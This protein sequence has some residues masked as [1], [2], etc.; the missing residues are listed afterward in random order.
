[1]QISHPSPQPGSAAPIG[2][3]R[4]WDAA[5]PVLL[6]EASLGDAAFQAAV[7]AARDKSCSD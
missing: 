5:F 2:H 4:C 1:M 6:L 7:K 3:S